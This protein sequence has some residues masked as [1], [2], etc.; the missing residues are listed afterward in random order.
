MSGISHRNREFLK[1]TQDFWQAQTSEKLT[2]EDARAC[3]ENIAG[4]FDVLKE[5]DEA[6][7]VS[8]SADAGER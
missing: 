8:R 4:F 5:W 1:R 6:A 2:L 3:V 7:S